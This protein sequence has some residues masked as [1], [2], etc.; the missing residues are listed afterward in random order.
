MPEVC[1]ALQD[2]RCKLTVLNLEGNKG[3]SDES[4]RMLCRSALTM[5]HCKLKKLDLSHCSLT[6][7]CIP[8]L[9][10]ALQDE[11]CVLNELRLYGNKFTEE[12]KKSLREIERHEHCKARGFKVGAFY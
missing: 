1:K 7:E 12:G 4:L 9:R 5:E 10:K 11:H 6:D 3:I 2:E 8:D